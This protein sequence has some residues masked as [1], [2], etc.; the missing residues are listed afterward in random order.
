VSAEEVIGSALTRTEEIRHGERVDTDVPPDLL[1]KIDPV[2][3]EQVLINLIENATK[4]GAPPFAIC[5]RSRGEAVE[6]EVA[7]HGPGLPGGETAHLFDKFVRASAA[8]GAGL[9][10]A[11]VR[12]IVQ[13]HGGTV[14][15]ENQPGGGAVFRVVL[16]TP[17]PPA[18]PAAIPAQ[19][20]S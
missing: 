1:L 18:S 11:V 8:P 7:D 15:A 14:A 12:A 20:A 13:A 16:P 17:A 9:G 3:F 6:I 19:A 2:L 4:H 5:A 10:L